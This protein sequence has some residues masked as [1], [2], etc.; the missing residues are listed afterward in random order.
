MLPPFMMNVSHLFVHK[1]NSAQ[2]NEPGQ[3]GYQLFEGSIP[4]FVYLLLESWDSNP[5][6]ECYSCINTVRCK[7]SFRFRCRQ[8]TELRPHPRI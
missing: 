4:V 5:N 8:G 2:L 1:A 3:S 7:L 6:L